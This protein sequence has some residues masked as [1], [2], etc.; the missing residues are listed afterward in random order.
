MVKISI[1]LV[2][3]GRECSHSRFCREQGCSRS[4]VLCRRECG[5]RASAASKGAHVPGWRGSR[6]GDCSIERCKDKKK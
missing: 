5:T 6:Q 3:R 1:R 2:S 4:R